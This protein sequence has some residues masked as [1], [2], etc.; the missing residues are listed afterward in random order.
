MLGRQVPV[1]LWISADLA[2]HWGPC[3]LHGQAGIGPS[4]RRASAWCKPAAV[5]LVMRVLR[6]FACNMPVKRL[7]LVCGKPQAVTICPSRLITGWAGSVTAVLSAMNAVHP[8]RLLPIM[9]LHMPLTKVQLPTQ[10]GA[11]SS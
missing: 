3:W 1:G 2:S 8:S 6:C 7:F 10:T 11:C 4:F 5:H 9:T